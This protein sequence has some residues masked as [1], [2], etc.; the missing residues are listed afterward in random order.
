MNPGVE[1][2]FKYFPN[3]TETQKQ[4]FSN[5]SELY[6]DWNAKINVIS[7][8]DMDQFYLHHVLH[9]LALVK[10]MQFKPGSSILDLGTGGGFPAIPL[11]IYYPEVQFL[12]VDSIGKKITVVQ[13]VASALGLGNLV[14]K[15]TRVEEV[16]E[17]FD[18][19]V[20][21]AVAPADKLIS[22]C[23]KNVSKQQNHALPNGLLA[24]K[25]GDLTMELK[26]FKKSASIFNISDYF[27]EEFFETKQVVHIQV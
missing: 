4:H 14:A 24:L 16:K 11:A 7:R 9:S 12:A 18:F 5:L 1:L 15:H 27:K 20:S 8:K 25:G 17:K 19:V 21:R 6:A 23:N 13:E 2:I 3:L 26:G 10:V 22:W